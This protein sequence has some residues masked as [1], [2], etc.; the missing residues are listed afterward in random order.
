MAT[1]Q[2]S[3]CYSEVRNVQ[4]A[5]RAS[6]Q[7]SGQVVNCPACGVSVRVPRPRQELMSETGA[8]R[9][10]NELQLESPDPKTEHVRSSPPLTTKPEC[11]AERP[12]PRCS[13]PVTKQFRVCPSCQLILESTRSGF[14]NAYKAAL[15]SIGRQRD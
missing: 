7:K 13:H 8:L 5:V 4:R 14:R 9:L 6:R 3:D 2:N 12:C 10:L 15:R 11:P 1:N